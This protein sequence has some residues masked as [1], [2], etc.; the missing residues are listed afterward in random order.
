[1]PQVRN[2]LCAHFGSH[3]ASSDAVRGAA[4]LLFGTTEQDFVSVE[5]FRVLVTADSTG[6]SSGT[7]KSLEAGLK[8]VLATRNADPDLTS[9]QLLGWYCIRDRQATTDLDDHELEFHK[10]NFRRAT[11]IAVLVKPEQGAGISIKLYGKAESA[12]ISHQ[13]YRSGYLRVDTA[14]L[15]D[16]PIDVTMRATVDDDCHLSV[17]RARD[18]LERVGTKGP[19][20][21]LALSIRRMANRCLRLNW[22]RTRVNSEPDTAAISSCDLTAGGIDLGHSMH[23]PQRQTPGL[24]VSPVHRDSDLHPSATITPTPLSL[25]SSVPRASPPVSV[26]RSPMRATR[27]SATILFLLVTGVIFAWVRLRGPTGSAPTRDPSPEISARTRLGLKVTGRKNKFVVTWDR[28][29]AGVKSAKRAILEVEDGSEHRTLQ[30]DPEQIANGSLVYESRV[31]DVTFRLQILDKQGLPITESMRV[32]DR[33]SSS[34]LAGPVTSPSSGKLVKGSSLAPGARVQARSNATPAQPIA[35]VEKGIDPKTAAAK[36]PNPR[37][38]QFTNR[39][40]ARSAQPVAAAH[41]ASQPQSDRGRATALQV[42]REIQKRNAPPASIQSP[43]GSEPTA[44]SRTKL[45]ADSSPIHTADSESQPRYTPPRVVRRVRPNT[46][47]LP[48][49]ELSASAD[50]EVQVR[51][52]ADGHVT[53]ASIVSNTPNEF[54][55]TAALSAAKE[56]AFEPAKL[57]GK[58]VPSDYRIVFHFHP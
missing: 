18:A 39:S 12:A 49:S 48:F 16:Q 9:L 28:N 33:F 45:L 11:D 13:N 56:W 52:D 44:N 19:W 6:N 14:V 58:S 34:S 57:R 21:R 1:M 53:E 54:L 29:A 22:R 7:I 4:G 27:V 42:P 20:H 24:N 36:P 10:R 32:V 3:N 40:K 41:F 2:G 8:G 15:A 25:Y 35:S 50:V 17:S 31:G 26:A 30:L 46:N 43:N 23:A 5:G 38:T 55:T 37:G 51:I 47:G